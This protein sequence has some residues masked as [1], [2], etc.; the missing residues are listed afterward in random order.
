MLCQFFCRNIS[1]P[2]ALFVLLFQPSCVVSQQSWFLGFFIISLKFS[3]FT[4]PPPSSCSPDVVSSTAP[5]LAKT[6]ISTHIPP[7]PAS[8]MLKSVALKLGPC[9]APHCVATTTLSPMGI[10][11]ENDDDA[12]ED[13]PEGLRVTCYS[14]RDGCVAVFNKLVFLLYLVNRVDSLGV[15]IYICLLCSVEW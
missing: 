10:M 13:L 6:A 14:P 15:F 5:S 3:R 1:Q 8:S 4:S 11:E 12:E 2:W 7:W 9:L